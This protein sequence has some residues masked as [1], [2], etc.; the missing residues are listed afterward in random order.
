M[1]GCTVLEVLGEHVQQLLLPHPA[2]QP[3]HLGG[4]LQHG[5]S[6]LMQ[7]VLADMGLQNRHHLICAGEL[8][9]Q[10]G[11]VVGTQVP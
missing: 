2:L 6:E 11:N 1:A 9:P 7:H 4:F 3:I 5:H 8:S 10:D